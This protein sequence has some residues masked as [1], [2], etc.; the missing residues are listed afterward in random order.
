MIVTSSKDK[1][2]A[3][4]V[5]AAIFFVALDRLLKAAALKYPAASLVL[6]E[7]L[8]FDPVKNQGIAFSLPLAGSWLLVLIVAA[9]FALIIA[10]VVSIKKQAYAG[11][12]FLLAVILGAASNLF[13]RLK[14]G[15]VI[16]YLELK[17][18]TVF[19]LADV[20]IVA[21]VI[22]IFMSAWFET[23]REKF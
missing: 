10:L 3:A 14:Y 16:D 5:A 8:K 4:G 2:I 21:G 19:N 9:I 17:Y 15:A 1:K 18:F 23:R 11:A 12:C 13:D 20:M 22:G 6:G 7:F